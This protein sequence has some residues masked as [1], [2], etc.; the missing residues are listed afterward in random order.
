MSSPDYTSDLSSEAPHDHS[1]NP[2]VCPFRTSRYHDQECSRYFDC[3]THQI[4]RAR[5]ERSESEEE[6]DE[7][8]VEDEGEAEDDIEDEEDE[9]DDHDDISLN[10]ALSLSED[11]SAY[12]EMDTG[13]PEPGSSGLESAMDAH[14]S[15]ETAHHDVIDL[16]RSSPEGGHEMA[17]ATAS[18]SWD[19]R[20]TTGDGSPPF[21]QDRSGQEPEVIDLTS[22]S[23]E[24][25]TRAGP[26][27]SVPHVERALPNLPASASGSIS[28]SHRSGGSGSPSAQ[29]RPGTPPSPPPPIRR[30]T[31]SNNTGSVR[32]SY[33]QQRTI[34]GGSPADLVLPRWQPDAEVTICPICHT[35]FSI[36][37]RK[38]HCRYVSL[39]PRPLLHSDYRP[40]ISLLSPENVAG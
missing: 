2:H 30:R 25:I 5:S 26:S 10:E 27:S 19:S 7:V 16:T 36:F 32:G 33:Q 34:E 17:G 38:H 24:P 18:G 20:S 35:Q 29:R 40:L 13:L 4:E 21:R 1:S 23:P 37:I 39:A 8:E 14:L 3:P 6:D 31:S 15:P 11:G 12:Q 28:S 22:D 9:E